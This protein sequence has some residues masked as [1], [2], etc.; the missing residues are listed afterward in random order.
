MTPIKKG[1]EGERA[2]KKN[3]IFLSKFF[4]KS[5]KTAFLTVF[6][7]FDFFLKIPP[8]LEKILDPPL[9]KHM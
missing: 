3:A 2:P 6:S 9:V 5:P 4:K 8:P 1:F 7:I